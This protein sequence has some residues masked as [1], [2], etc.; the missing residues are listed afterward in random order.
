MTPLLYYGAMLPPTQS[1]S[2]PAIAVAT[3][4]TPDL[5][6][7]W[8]YIAHHNATYAKRHGYKWITLTEVKGEPRHLTWQKI[9]MAMELLEQYDY[10]WTIDADL[11]IMDHGFK[12]EN[13]IAEYSSFDVIASSDASNSG[14]RD[15]PNLNSGSLLYKN[16]RWT[17]EFLTRVWHE[18][19][20]FV[21]KYFHEQSVI[22]RMIQNDLHLLNHIKILPEK[23][24]NS[25]F[26]HT[27]YQSG[28]FVLH[29]M[30]ISNQERLELIPKYLTLS[31]NSCS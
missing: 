21:Y 8:K 20:E 14:V 19:D 12:L 7:F 23:A 16:T 29:L 10:L 2:K 15:R 6:Y 17:K 9:Q 13:I 3:F 4:A 1:P 11:I 18:A 31:L 22:N 5:D 28:D 26:P 24:L 25:C 30:A 27:S